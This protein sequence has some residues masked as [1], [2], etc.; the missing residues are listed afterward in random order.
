MP[1]GIIAPTFPQRSPSRLVWGDFCQGGASR[2]LSIF[3]SLSFFVRPESRFFAPT[4]TS[5]RQRAQERSR[6]AANLA[7]TARL[8][9]DGSEHDGR[10]AVVG[11]RSRGARVCARMS[12]HN[13][14]FG[15]SK[16]PNHDAVM[17]IGS[18][19]RGGG[20]ILLI[21]IEAKPWYGTP[22]PRT[23]IGAV[24]GVTGR[25]KPSVALIDPSVYQC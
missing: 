17:R 18:E 23:V 14:V 21:G 19:L 15:G 9:L 20:P 5:R 12:C 11:M 4:H 1:A 7:A 10:L 6:L 25:P 24:T 16:D 13:L 3:S 8:G 22:P 2:V